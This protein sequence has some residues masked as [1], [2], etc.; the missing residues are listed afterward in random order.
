MGAR[1]ARRSRGGR[2]R[3]RSLLAAALVSQLVLVQ[4]LLERDGIDRFGEPFWQLVLVTLKFS[5][6]ALRA[7][8]GPASLL[9]DIDDV[10]EAIALGLDPAFRAEVT[11]RLREV[12]DAVP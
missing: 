2:G 5:H 9:D 7:S 11:T 3:R 1:E 12:E 4:Q 10:M 6:E 8:R